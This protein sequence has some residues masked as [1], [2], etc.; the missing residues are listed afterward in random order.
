MMSRMPRKLLPF[1][2]RVVVLL[3]SASLVKA[4]EGAA[5]GPS[6]ADVDGKQEE[7]LGPTN[8]VQHFPENGCIG[9]HINAPGVLSQAVVDWTKS[10]HSVNQVTCD[11]CHGGDPD[12]TGSPNDGLSVEAAH[13]SPTRFIRRPRPI[14]VSYFCGQCHVAIMEK[15]LGSP[16][17]ENVNPTCIFCHGHHR[18]EAPTTSIIKPGRCTACH[19][20]Q[21]AG[22]V[23]DILERTESTIAE[24]EEL[25]GVL[26]TY[27]YRNLALDEM[28]HHSQSTITQLRVAFHSFNLGEVTNFASQ[29]EAVL[30]Q[31]RR[32]LEV[33]QDKEAARKVQVR[34][35]VVVAAFVLLFAVLLMQYKRLY[36]D[37]EDSMDGLRSGLYTGS[38]GG[39]S[40]RGG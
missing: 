8:V 39:S 38:S 40:R 13:F 29:L 22:Q 1:I 32:T 28:H 26:E 24:L 15:H 3:L 19:D 20:F 12:V 2:L 14:K 17:G 37:L 27:H 18:V 36:L 35:G 9:C 21:N 6:G 5:H 30:E 4:G 34:I 31:T 7:K 25:A 33:V 23:R 10:I 16:H 11:S